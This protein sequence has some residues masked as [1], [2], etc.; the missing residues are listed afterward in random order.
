MANISRRDFLK[1]AGLASAVY[2]TGS[3]IAEAG[4]EYIEPEK[5]KVIAGIIQGV[6]NEKELEQKMAE[7]NVQ[8]TILMRAM[9]NDKNLWDRAQ[10]GQNYVV[11][12]AEGRRSGI[13]MASRHYFSN[14]EE[15]GEFL[16][17]CAREG[18]AFYCDS[19]NTHYFC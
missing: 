7:M 15:C 1:Y 12:V 9:I 19:R 4:S 6:I 13:L 3:P 2:L 16:K 17:Q 8:S 18:K 11:G 5:R 10:P 14:G